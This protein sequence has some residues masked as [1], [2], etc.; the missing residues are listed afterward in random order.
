[1]GLICVRS[2]VIRRCLSTTG[3]VSGENCSVCS[4]G[5]QNELFGG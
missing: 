5:R 3:I 1:M 2:H 4:T